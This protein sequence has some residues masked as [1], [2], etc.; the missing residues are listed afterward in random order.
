[1]PKLAAIFLIFFKVTLVSAQDTAFFDNHGQRVNT[2]ENCQ[3]YT[4]TYKDSPEINKATEKSYSKEGQIISENTFLLPIDNDKLEHR[5]K[6]YDGKFK[7]WYQNGLLH[8]EIDYTS[9]KKNGKLLTYWQN[10]KA[11]REDILSEGVLIKGNCFSST[12]SDTAYY[13]YERIPEFPGGTEKYKK[14]LLDNL[15]TTWTT[16][17]GKVIVQFSIGL[18]GSIINLKV[19][20]SANPEL[21]NRALSIIERMPHWTPAYQDGIP[22]IYTQRQG[23]VFK[24]NK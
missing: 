14:Y 18:D 3:F 17:E 11:K 2:L 9:G 24:K 16:I 15:I 6:I 10:G 8:E 13:D 22:K 12:G 5:N 1:M 19:V 21:D 7:T 20:Q 23:F 4:I